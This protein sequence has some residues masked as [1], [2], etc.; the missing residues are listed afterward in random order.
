MI[1]QQPQ[2]DFAARKRAELQ[3]P[4][5]SFAEGEQRQAARPPGSAP[6]RPAPTDSTDR[7]AS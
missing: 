5:R 6:Q 3:G 1:D 4:P 2:G 7:E